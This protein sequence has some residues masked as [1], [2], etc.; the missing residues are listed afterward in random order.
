MGL[1][2]RLEGIPWTRRGADF[3]EGVVSDRS[4]VNLLSEAFTSTWLH[5]RVKTRAQEVGG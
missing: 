1:F 5:L 3:G 2:E 4:Q